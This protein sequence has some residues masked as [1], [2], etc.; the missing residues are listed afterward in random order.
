MIRTMIV[1]LLAVAFVMGFAFSSFA[2]KEVITGKVEKIDPAKAMVTL[3]PAGGAAR[4]F[5]DIKT[6][7]DKLMGIKPGDTIQIQIEEDGTLVVVDEDA[8]PKK[9]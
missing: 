3:K 4:E 1:G 9:K 2:A 8:S 7:T 5:Q 6:P